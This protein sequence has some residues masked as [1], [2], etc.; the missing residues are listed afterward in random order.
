MTRARPVGA[1]PPERADRDDAKSIA[2]AVNDIATEL[3]GLNDR[4]LDA[5]LFIA[6]RDDLVRRLRRIARRAGAPRERPKPTT[7]WRP[8]A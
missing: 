3:N 7:T 6:R 4:R 8:N 2:Q 1:P 5:E